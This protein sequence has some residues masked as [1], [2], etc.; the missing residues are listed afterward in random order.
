MYILG[1]T[2]YLEYMVF[3]MQGGGLSSY[4]KIQSNWSRVCHCTI[5]LCTLCLYSY[6]S[7]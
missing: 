2:V 1:I 5:C 6:F 7:V 3:N 4:P